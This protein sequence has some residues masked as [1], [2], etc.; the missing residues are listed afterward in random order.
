M[1]FFR[2]KTFCKMS[3]NTTVAA[4][5]SVFLLVTVSRRLLRTWDEKIYGAD[6]NPSLP[7]YVL[8][9]SSIPRSG[10][11]FLAEMLSSLEDSV[12]FFEPLWP[13]ERGQ[14]IQDDACVEKFL[15]GVFGC[16]FTGQFEDWLRSKP[17]FLRYFN[18]E[19]SQCDRLE[20]REK[21]QCFRSLPLRETCSNSTVRLVKVVRARMHS[22]SKVMADP[23][24]NFKLVH[25][26]RDPRGAMESISHFAG[27]DKDPA[28]RCRGLE[29]DLDT[30][31]VFSDRYPSKVFRVSYERLCLYP[32]QEVSKILGFV[33]DVPPFV[34]PP[35]EAY[36]NDH[37][38]V[39]KGKESLST[40]KVSE[41]EYFAWRWRISEG[42]LK[43]VEGEPTCLRPIQRL[44]HTVF[45]SLERVRNV[46]L[47]LF[48]P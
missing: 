26:T 5:L 24:V 9:L 33:F 19:A 11:T 30:Y 39:M 29:E 43:S 28:E 36:I 7:I 20:G 42:L 34:P 44:Q 48:A 25:L 23:E 14:C 35:V 47:Q 15:L 22:F 45:G 21:D 41:R 32:L 1:A 10:S 4:A 40:Y 12:L 8:I 37:T 46:S 3:L 17:T 16:N 31:E 2:R 18:P 6:T 27:W 38:K 13:L